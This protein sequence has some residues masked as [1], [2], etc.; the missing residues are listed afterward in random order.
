M[1]PERE[2][3][4]IRVLNNRQ[5]DLA[6]VME[7]ISDP[8]NIS[9]VMRTCDAVGVQEIFVLNN[10]INPHRDFG[11]KS[12]AS[13]AGWLTIHQFTNTQQ[14]MEAIKQRYD[15]VYATHLGVASKSLYD[16]NLTEKVALVFGNE[17]SG[18]TEEC[19]SYCNGN[20]IIPQVG[21]VQSLNISV[22]CAVSLYEAFRQRN[23][24]GYYNSTARL[25]QVQRQDLANKWGLYDME[26]GE[27]W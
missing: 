3:K 25:P 9:A 2:A 6:I 14:C 21:M 26:A 13:A 5:P 4:I 11:K 23:V 17:H 12:S 22:A 7:N 15:R 1:T 8:H 24:A 27:E 20:F 18:V 16:L 19:L 10:V